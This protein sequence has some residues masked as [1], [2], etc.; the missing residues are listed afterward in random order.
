MPARV[1]LYPPK[2]DVDDAEYCQGAKK[3]LQA[4][5]LFWGVAAWRLS[6][7]CVNTLGQQPM[8]HGAFMALARPTVGASGTSGGGTAVVCCPP[9]W[10]PTMEAFLVSLSTVAIAEMGDRTQLLALVLAAHYR[11]PWPILAGILCATLA[12][13]AVAGYIGAHLGSY[14]TPSRLDLIVGV[15]MIAM[16]LWS[17]KADKLDERDAEPKRASAFVATLVA[18][19][20]AEIGDKTQIATM[21]LAAAYSNLALVVAGTTLGMLLA[22]G[23]V[24]FLGNAFS[25][26][27]PL[28][29]MHI[30]ASLLFLG[31]GALF[32]WRGLRHA[33]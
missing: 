3:K 14:L 23:P 31:L 32:I 6:R 13:H 5:F 15:S 25:K 29:A 33:P 19:F 12:N 17:L 4:A 20:V 21:A 24:V 30:G 8:A 9:G 7:P 28:K 2:T 27:L 16:A 22:N 11:K 26:R 10:S 1:A 18:F